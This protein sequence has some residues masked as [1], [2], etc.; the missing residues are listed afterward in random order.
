[1]GTTVRIRMLGNMWEFVVGEEYD[2]E[3]DRANALTGMGMAVL[4]DAAA[5]GEED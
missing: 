2:V 4:V 3:I 1:M 5:R